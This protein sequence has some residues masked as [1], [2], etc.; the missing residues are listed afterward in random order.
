MLLIH[1]PKDD[2]DEPSSTG[3]STRPP[4]EPKEIWEVPEAGHVGARSPSA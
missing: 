4:G 1:S 3:R 2:P